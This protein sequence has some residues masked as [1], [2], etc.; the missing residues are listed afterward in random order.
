MKKIIL[1]LALLTISCSA[2]KK[3]TG[4]PMYKDNAERCLATVLTEEFDFQRE[5]YSHIQAH[6]CQGNHKAVVN[7]RWIPGK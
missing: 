5:F 3:K 7:L 2:T 4:K 1:I 6:D